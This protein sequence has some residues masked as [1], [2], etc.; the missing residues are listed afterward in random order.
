MQTWIFS[1]DTLHK[2][3]NRWVQSQIDTGHPKAIKNAPFVGKAIL[4]FLITS[5]ALYK[6]THAIAV[7]PKRMTP[8][9]PS[10]VT[11]VSP[12]ADVEEEKTAD[13]SNLMSFEEI[14]KQW[15]E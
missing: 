14:E 10:A 15:Y 3:I 13:T 4:D 1:R 5:E 12:D 9:L 2:E 11:A 6:K 7:Q 8:S